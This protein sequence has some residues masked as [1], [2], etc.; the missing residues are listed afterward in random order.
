MIK[1]YGQSKNLPEALQVWSE[2]V[3]AKAKPDE[4]IFL[5]LVDACAYNGQPGKAYE[6]FKLAKAS[7]KDFGAYSPAIYTA[8]LRGLTQKG[9]LE[10]A[11]EV[12]DD[13]VEHHVVVF[14]AVYN[15]LLECCAKAGNMSSA[16]RVFKGML[17]SQ[18]ARPDVATYSTIIKGYC[19]HG[20]L[21]QSL[22]LFQTMRRAGLTGDAVLFNALLEGCTKVDMLTLGE[23]IL[24]DME[25]AEVAPTAL[26]LR[27]LTKLYSS[28]G[29]MDTAFEVT[30]RLAK[31]YDL[32]MD[33]SVVTILLSGCLANGMMVKA[34]EVFMKL[35][36]PDAKVYNA[37]INGC[38]KHDR[39]EDAVQFHEKA[40]VAGITVDDEITKNTCFMG[41]RRGLDMS[42]LETHANGTSWTSVKTG[43]KPSRFARSRRS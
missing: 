10:M 36:R 32:F 18:S 4:T 6:A 30:E 2:I 22:E 21:M 19:M 29:D 28:A 7:A 24:A 33:S 20:E 3:A 14:S 16:S 13:M 12:Y 1:A 8:L 41:K 40:V 34:T 43:D 5:A 35:E 11:L 31:K 25:A 17:S 26:T 9:N 38:L 39:V 23:Q 27:L 37:M 42:M 15:Q